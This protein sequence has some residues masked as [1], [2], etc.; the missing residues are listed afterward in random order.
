MYTSFTALALKVYRV[1]AF[2]TVTSSATWSVAAWR[3]RSRRSDTGTHC[4][5]GGTRF[6]A[7]LVDGHDQFYAETEF[8][9]YDMVQLPDSMVD[10]TLW[11]GNLNEFTKDGQLSDL[12]QQ[13]CSGLLSVPCVIARRPNTDSLGYGFVTFPTQIE[14]EAALKFD[15]YIIDGKA[16]KVQKFKDSS[17]ARAK[18]P[19]KLVAYVVG[20]K[21]KLPNGSVNNLRRI[22]RDDVERLS[23]GQPA[24]KKGYG[25]R[26]VPHR[27]NENERSSFERAVKYGFVTLDGTGYRRGRKGSPLAN[28]HR[29]W[30]DSRAKPQI[31]LCK[32]TGGRMLDNVIIDLSTLR[33]GPLDTGDIGLDLLHQWKADILL[34]AGK[35]D[36]ILVD[37]YDEDN[38]FT[39]EADPDY[40]SEDTFFEMTIDA[41]AW[42]FDP[43][44]KLPSVSM[45]VF[46]GERSKAKSMAREL[47]SLWEV[48]E[49]V[50]VQTGG[51]KSGGSKGPKNRRN[52]G[53][54]GGGKTKM[55]GLSKHRRQKNVRDV[56][57]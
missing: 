6:F 18:V 15:G 40:E 27:L 52:A 11:V 44:W 35:A 3:Q 47:A 46:E 48:P 42:A 28:I 39:V 56:S 25:S 10:T 5:S 49:E 26:R 31:I 43:I 45:G 17:L 16:I 12:F 51:L 7:S 30:C 57:F 37:E 4:G 2:S 22:S 33:V 41:D 34:A 8:Q 19:E 29:Q 14:A 1:R 38:T 32:A 36:M 54:R 53:A 20:S 55:K 24:K 50:E 9:K 13:C 23:R 21:K